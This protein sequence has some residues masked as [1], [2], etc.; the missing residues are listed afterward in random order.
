MTDFYSK[1]YCKKLAF[2]SLFGSKTR[3]VCHLSAAR[4]WQRFSSL[5]QICL[6]RS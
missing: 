1:W 4:R 5:K 2:S 3:Y 6:G